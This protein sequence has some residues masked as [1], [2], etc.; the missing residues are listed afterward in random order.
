VACPPTCKSEYAE[1][2]IKMDIKKIICENFDG[3]K[4]CLDGVH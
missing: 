3:R 1:D 2:N 4:G